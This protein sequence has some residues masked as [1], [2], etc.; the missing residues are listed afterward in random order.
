MSRR[1]SADATRDERGGPR[2]S[3]KAGDQLCDGRFGLIKRVGKSAS[4]NVWLALNNEDQENVLVCALHK[5][6][7]SAPARQRQVFEA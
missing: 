5:H 1:T 2:M 7:A 6:V 4:T 3:M